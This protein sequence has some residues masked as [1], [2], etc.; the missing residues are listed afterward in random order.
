MDI[1][2]DFFHGEDFLRE[3]DAA[4]AAALRSRA[5]SGIPQTHTPSTATTHETPIIT[6]A[7]MNTSNKQQPLATAAASAAGA[8]NNRPDI[9]TAVVTSQKLP[10]PT[11]SQKSIDACS[12]NDKGTSCGHRAVVGGAVLSYR[13]AVESISVRDGATKAHEEETVGKV[14]SGELHRVFLGWVELE[15]GTVICISYIPRKNSVC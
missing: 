2:E 13:W 14:S 6:T 1:D 7:R 9:T 3:V 4:E 8:N 5:I 10:E 15:L 11:T 12:D